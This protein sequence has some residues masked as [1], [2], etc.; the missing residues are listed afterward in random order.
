M[1]PPL[2][3]LARGIRY[4]YSYVHK[5]SSSNVTKEHLPL[6]GSRC[7][8]S[9][10][11]ETFTTK[12]VG[13]V[14]EHDILPQ[15]CKYKLAATVPQHPD[16]YLYIYGLSQFFSDQRTIMSLLCMCRCSRIPNHNN[17]NTSREST[18]QSASELIKPRYMHV[19]SYSLPPSLNR[20]GVQ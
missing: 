5:F 4:I 6:M 8:A 9:P 14:M 13:S 12:D 3:P 2:T 10:C 7:L 19:L 17:E 1:C 11:G 20:L 16:S 18:L 15:L